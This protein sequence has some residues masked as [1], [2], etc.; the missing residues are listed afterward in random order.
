MSR[1]KCKLWKANQNLICQHDDKRQKVKCHS[2]SGCAPSNSVVLPL[3]PSLTQI[4]WR[5][6]SLSC[7][8]H[9][10]ELWPLLLLCSGLA[11]LYL[12]EYFS[13]GF[14]CTDKV[15][16]C[17]SSYKHQIIFCSIFQIFSFYWKVHNL[18]VASSNFTLLISGC[19][20]NIPEA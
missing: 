20:T 13:W 15:A 2:S 12:T 19:D 10:P 14:T 7:W 16:G 1:A 5:Y 6:W 9:S 11:P 18:L 8:S 4:R 17:V 3:G